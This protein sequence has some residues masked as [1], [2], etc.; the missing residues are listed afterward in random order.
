MLL[1]DGSLRWGSWFIRAVDEVS[2]TQNEAFLFEAAGI[3]SLS[4]FCALKGYAPAPETSQLLRSYQKQKSWTA[5][6]SSAR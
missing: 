6:G 4:V 5:T 1:Y 2:A 3:S